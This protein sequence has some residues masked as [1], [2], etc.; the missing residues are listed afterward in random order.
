MSVVLVKAPD[1]ISMTIPALL[2][3]S[4]RQ[5]D[6]FLS[7]I[8]VKPGDLRLVYDAFHPWCPCR[9]DRA[10]NTQVLAWLDWCPCSG[11]FCC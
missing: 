2:K 8:A 5:S 1:I 6:V 9:I 3:S 7:L 10:G 11:F 4:S